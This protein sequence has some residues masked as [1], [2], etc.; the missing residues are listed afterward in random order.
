MYIIQLPCD[1]FCLSEF[2]SGKREFTPFMA[3]FL[4]FPVMT[5]E[6]ASLSPKQSMEEMEP[7]VELLPIEFQAS[8]SLLSLLW[9]LTLFTV[10][11]CFFLSSSFGGPQRTHLENWTKVNFP[12]RYEALGNAQAGALNLG[13]SVNRILNYEAVIMKKISITRKEMR[14]YYESYDSPTLWGQGDEE[15]PAKETEKM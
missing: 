3:F 14:S 10:C 6:D 13:F 11:H 1:N 12:W 4:L 7:I 8:W 15:E 2:G 9:S 5:T